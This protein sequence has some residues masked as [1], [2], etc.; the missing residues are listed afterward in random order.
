M[1]KKYRVETTSKLVKDDSPA[2]ETK[3]LTPSDFTPLVVNTV[4]NVA[5]GAAVVAIAFVGADTVRRCLVHIV[6]TKI[7]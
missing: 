6:A 4:Q 3:P 5:A 2:A 1:F 7:Q